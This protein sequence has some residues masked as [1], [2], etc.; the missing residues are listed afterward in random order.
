[1]SC[2]AKMKGFFKWFKS[3]TKIKRWILLI[4][5]G[6]LLCC[7]GMAEVLT[8]KQMEFIDFARIA[9]I[10]V[11]FFFFIVYSIIAI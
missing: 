7:Y 6:V 2:K 5:I 1:M 3:N 4:I 10:F 8:S 9:V 11:F